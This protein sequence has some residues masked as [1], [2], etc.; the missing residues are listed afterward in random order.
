MLDSA[1]VRRTPRKSRKS[2][3]FDHRF[4]PACSTRKD[5]LESLRQSLGFNLFSVDFYQLEST[6]T[7]KKETSLECAPA[8]AGPH[9]ASLPWRFPFS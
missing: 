4:A 6:K 1:G 8:P 7:R 9:V 3:F 2:R 5:G